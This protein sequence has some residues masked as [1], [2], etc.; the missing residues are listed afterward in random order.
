MVP[1]FA[2]HPEQPGIEVSAAVERDPCVGE[3]RPQSVEEQLGWRQEFQA[4]HTAVSND[5]CRAGSVLDGWLVGEDVA[6]TAERLDI[7]THYVKKLR[8]TIRHRALDL[9]DV[10][11]AA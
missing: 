10:W 11:R 3:A 6:E 4:V 2:Q 1:L 7:S 8:G 9:S 5:N